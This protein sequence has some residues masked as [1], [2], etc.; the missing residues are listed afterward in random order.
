MAL[1]GF[2]PSFV[3]DQYFMID[4][5]VIEREVRYGELDFSDTVLEIGPGLGFL[6]EQL[7][8][9]VQKVI[10]IEKDKRL[11][12]VL[13]QELKGYANIEYIWQDVLEAKLP[14]FDKVISNIPYSISAPL[15]FKLL[16][17]DFKKAVLCYQ[18]EF[19]EKMVTQAGSN[20]Y[21]RLSVMVQY[22]FEPKILEVVPKN[23]F[24]PQPKVDSAIVSL[25]K[26][27]NVK[28]EPDFD[29]FIRELF[30][31]P[32]KDV[33][34][35][36]KNAFGKEIEDSRKMFTLDIPELRKLYEKLK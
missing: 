2:R 10:A 18:K 16:D 34:N 14:K 36:V 29:V 22:Y 35:S 15:T 5:G 26:K 19:A 25:V 21:G 33:R 12:P 3:L 4:S 6:T 17:Y 7:A 1:Y 24:Y 9:S 31:Y 8:R 13:S 32:S 20:D 27:D 11:E 28:R 23:A 30:R